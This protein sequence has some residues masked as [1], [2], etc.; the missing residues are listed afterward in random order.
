MSR[1]SEKPAWLR[2]WLIRHQHPVSFWLHM[3]G[4]PLTIAAIPL[5][6]M[7]LMDGRWDLWWRP[8]LLIVGGYLLQWIGHIIEGN[9]MGEVILVKK[10][11]GKSYQAVS[12]RYADESQSS[13]E[14]R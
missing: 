3:I 11:L 9:D 12:P 7:Q 2:N 5:A 1:Q 8:V 14:N 13:N 6:I 10:W 4:I